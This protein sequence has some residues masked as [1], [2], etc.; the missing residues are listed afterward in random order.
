MDLETESKDTE[1]RKTESREPQT[2]EAYNREF[3]LATGNG[4]SH[5]VDL[6]TEYRNTD[7]WEPGNTV[8]YTHEAGHGSQILG[9]RI[10]GPVPRF[11]DAG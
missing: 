7:P 5:S 3:E 8:I 4:V 6:F 10:L 11:P 9:S 1:F 2:T